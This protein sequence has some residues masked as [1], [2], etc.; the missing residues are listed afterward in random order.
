MAGAMNASVHTVSENLTP[1]DWAFW[2]GPRLCDKVSCLRQG[3]LSR[4]HNLSRQVNDVCMSVWCSALI[5]CWIPQCSLQL[6]SDIVLHYQHLM[7]GSDCPIQHSHDFVFVIQS[8][9]LF[10]LTSCHCNCKSLKPAGHLPNLQKPCN[11]PVI[12]KHF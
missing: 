8:Q 1:I 12:N 3:V 5:V 4:S 7:N 11:L 6:R 9:Q 2:P 10:S